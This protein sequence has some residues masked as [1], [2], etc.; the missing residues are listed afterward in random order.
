[1]GKSPGATPSRKRSLSVNECSKSSNVVSIFVSRL[2]IETF[3]LY[4]STLR[5]DLND[6]KLCLNERGSFLFAFINFRQKLCINDK[7]PQFT[8]IVKNC[9]NNKGPPL[10][11]EKLCIHDK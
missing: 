10:H 6:K 3:R 8:F 7:C 11:S 9:I 1:M 4:C 5:T 2:R